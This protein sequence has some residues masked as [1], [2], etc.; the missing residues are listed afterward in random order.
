ML[1]LFSYNRNLPTWGNS[2]DNLFFAAIPC[3]D[4][5]VTKKQFLLIPLFIL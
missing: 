4:P 3:N 5:L 2:N 1:S